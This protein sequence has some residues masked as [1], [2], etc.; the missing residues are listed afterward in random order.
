MD[1]RSRREFLGS[2]GGGML[3]AS[4]GPQLAVDLGL[5]P[6]FRETTDD[7]LHF[8]DLEPLVVLL[9]ET[10]ADDLQPLLVQKLRSGTELRTLVAA[11]ALANARTFGGQDYVGFHC[12]MALLPAYA[13]AARMPS[14][15]RPLPVLKVLYRNTARIQEYGGR[16][17]EVLRKVEPSG[18]TGGDTGPRLR[19]LMRGCDMEEAERAFA[20]QEDPNAAYDDLLWLVQDGS[21]VHRTVLAWR[22]W[23]TLRL[24]GKSH[25]HTML[26]QSVRYCVQDE[27]TRKL[28][29]RPEP[30][31]RRV[32]PQL[33]EEHRAV[34]AVFGRRKADDAWIDD[35]SRTI[36]GSTCEQAAAAVAAALAEGFAPNDIG[37]AMS[38]AA[39]RLLLHDPGRTSDPT[40]EKPLGSVHGATFGVHASDAANAWRQI[41]RVGNPR[42]RVACLIAGAYHTAGQSQWVSDEPFLTERPEGLDTDQPAALLA[43]TEARL[44]EGDQAGT[45]AFVERYGQLDHAPRPMFDLLL[46]FGVSADGAL[47]AEKYYNTVEEE[48]A[49]GRGRFRWRH[50]V[51]LGRVTASEQTI[52]APGLA[53]AR[54]LLG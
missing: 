47:H 29:Q 19:A 42:N 15:L 14:E 28:H 25:A 3:A 30:G 54:E 26:R 34:E 36:F 17:K 32:L 48:F 11:A 52:P 38:L 5:T 41:A 8:G 21:D 27:E 4:L 6:L 2:V 18:R 39:N 49:A 33:L 22:A 50:V 44:R 24:V 7:R 10:P 51:G 20:A 12:E 46:K 1:L 37:E 16:Q 43:A 31:I 9:Q 13:M 45:C 40:P 23:D 35:M 53:Q